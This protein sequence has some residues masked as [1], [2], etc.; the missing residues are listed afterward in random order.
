MPEHRASIIPPKR[1]LIVRLGSMGDIIHTLPAVQVLRHT[2]RETIIGWVVE[3]RWAELL[4]TLPTPRSGPRSPQRPLVDKVHTV[5]TKA[6]RGSL[7]SLQTIEQIAAAVSE[8]RAP[9]YEIAIDFQ[10]AVRSALIARLARA[11]TIAGFAQPRESF[12][13][14]FYSRKI[15]TSGAHIVQQNLS[16]AAA[17][18]GMSPTV[19][20]EIEFPHDPA[21]EQK[22]D[23]LLHSLAVSRF[24]VLSPGAG[25]GA[26]QW[27]A[28]R[29]GELAIQLAC[30][31]LRLLINYGPGE[32]HLAQQ[33]E[34]R[35]EGSAI[36]ISLSLTQLIALMRRA[37]LFIGGDSGPLHMA[38][39]LHIPVVA[40]FG[41][42]NPSRNGP[43]GTRSIVLRS[44][45]SRTSLSH[46]PDTDPGLL[47]ISAEQVAARA[48]QLLGCSHE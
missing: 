35:S 13:S 42:T 16:L 28:A 21:A 9:H 29:Y 41:P 14:M 32:E 38:A 34:A 1:I 8:L 48:Q 17:I 5:N 10:G 7:A 20:P 47:E 12:A 27:P 30:G 31:G 18:A 37:D 26:K 15:I 23:Q 43:F 33:I 44:S 6:W 11:T 2:F 4:C 19:A 24:V 39:A 36:A 25:W 22:C 40:I 3:E 45:S 46:R